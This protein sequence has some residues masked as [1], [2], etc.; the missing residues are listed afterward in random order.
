MGL[1]LAVRVARPLGFPRA[2][3]ASQPVVEGGA[4]APEQHQQGHLAARGRQRVEGAC[5]RV[6]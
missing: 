5:R 3:E 4:D 1:M 6:L 2:G